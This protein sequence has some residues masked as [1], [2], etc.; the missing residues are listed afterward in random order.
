MT[1]AGPICGVR[2]EVVSDRFHIYEYAVY[3]DSSPI[4]DAR[5]ARTLSHGF[6]IGRRIRSFPPLPTRLVLQ[7]VRQVGTN[8][9]RRTVTVFANQ[10]FRRLDPQPLSSVIG[11]FEVGNGRVGGLD[12]ASFEDD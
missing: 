2:G 12:S 8:Q 9:Q 6:D 11:L 10:C 5:Q 1:A 4:A 7:L 3:Q